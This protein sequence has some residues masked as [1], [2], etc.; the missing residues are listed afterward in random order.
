MTVIINGTTGITTPAIDS[1]ARFASEDMPAGSVLQV[2]QSLNNT[3]IGWSDGSPQ[4][5]VAMSI[6]VK[7]GSLVEINFTAMLAN[8]AVTSASW[9]SMAFIYL[10]QNNSEIR[11][12]E[13][14]GDLTSNSAYRV[15]NVAGSHLTGALSAG[16]HTFSLLIDPY[17]PQAWVLN[18]G[19]PSNMILKEIAQ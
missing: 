4:T 13:H 14:D 16:T 8:T 17:S 2:V 7:S 6:L 11:Q 15:Y 1:E 5:A 18:R 12:Y 9:S 10:L 3:Q 19:R